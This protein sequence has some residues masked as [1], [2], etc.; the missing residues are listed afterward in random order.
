[1][2]AAAAVDRPAALADRAAPMDSRRLMRFLVINWQDRLN[3]RSGGAEVHLHETFGR[4]AASGHDVTLLVS[5]WRGAPA[6]ERLDGMDVHRVGSRH[7]FAAAA[8][9]YYLRHLRREPFDVVVEDLNKVPLGAPLWAGSPVV[10]L[11]HHLFGST[12]FASASPPVAAATWLSERPLPLVYGRVPVEVVS[13]STADDLVA[14]GFD[15]A[16]IR[17]IPNGVDLGFYHPDPGVGR[18]RDPTL[19]YVGRLQSYK[20]VDLLVRAVAELRDRGMAVRLRVA[21]RGAEQPRLEALAREL[22]V[23]DRV[24]FTGFVDDEEK[25]RLLRSAWLHVLTSPKEG[26]GL[27]VMEAAACATPTVGSRS[28][29]LRD[30][31]IDGETGLL[32]PHGDVSALADAIARL[33]GDRAR[34]EAMGRAARA[35]S[36]TFTWERTARDTE[37][38][39]ASVLGLTRSTDTRTGEGG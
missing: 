27:T 30:S 23:A 29:G 7:T 37:A 11:V 34:V 38:H 4:L 1:M 20:R 22:G 17:V 35:R 33:V 5:G 3:P 19:V 39:L 25:R 36:E 26:W 14:R 15:G 2:N 16:R 32:V 24:E 12:A 18:T 13:Q 31:V 8:V 6:R 21:G 10:L 9:P 28:P